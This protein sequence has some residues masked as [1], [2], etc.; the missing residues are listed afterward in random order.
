MENSPQE[1]ADMLLMNYDLAL[2]TPL[3]TLGNLKNDM[4]VQCAII[5]VTNTI[6]A[7]KN[8]TDKYYFIEVLT[9]FKS[10]L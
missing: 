8:I 5:D 10:K 7:I 3:V 6:G 9:I 1:Y 4:V 2:S